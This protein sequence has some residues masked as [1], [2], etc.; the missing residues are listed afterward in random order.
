MQSPGG[1]LYYIYRG[2][3]NRVVPLVIM[4]VGRLTDFGRFGNPKHCCWVLRAV[5]IF[6]RVGAV[7]LN[8]FGIF[9]SIRDA[10]SIGIIGGAD[11]LRHFCHQ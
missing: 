5:G 2:Y 6:G 11:G 9:I 10:A 1:L 3:R 4:G 7:A 8:H